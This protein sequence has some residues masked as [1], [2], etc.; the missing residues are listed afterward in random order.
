MCGLVVKLDSLI[1]INTTLGLLIS[2]LKRSKNIP[3]SENALMPIHGSEHFFSVLGQ[4]F[5]RQNWYVG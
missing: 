4:I 5:E 1:L 2:A 3:K